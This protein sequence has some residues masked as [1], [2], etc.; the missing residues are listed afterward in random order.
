MRTRSATDPIA[1]AETERPCRSPLPDPDDGTHRYG[2]DMARRRLTADWSIDVDER[3]LQRV[4]D[5]SLQ[6]LDVGPPVRTIWMSVWIMPDDSSAD[7]ELGRIKAHVPPTVVRRF[8]EPGT[9]PDERRL[10]S[11]YPERD[12]DGRTSWGLY[13]YTIRPACWVQAA[14]L[15]DSED[16]LDWALDTWRS[17]RYEPEPDR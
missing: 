16:D 17:L 7:E 3:V 6:M 2:H 14:F 13:A 8:E 9:D 4:V 1:G 12:E 11:W 5:G 15:S 10:A